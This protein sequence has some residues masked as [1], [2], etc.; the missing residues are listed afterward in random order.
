MRGRGV[1]FSRCHMVVWVIRTFD[2]GAIPVRRMRRVHRHLAIG[3]AVAVVLVPVTLT[4]AVAIQIPVSLW[5]LGISINVG[6]G[7]HPLV[8][9]NPRSK[10]RCAATGRQLCEGRVMGVA[11]RLSLRSGHG[12]HV[13]L[14]RSFPLGKWGAKSLRLHWLGIL[15]V[16]ISLVLSLV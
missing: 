14:P 8:G 1:F 12:T 15:T 5:I 7:P 3:R 13:R 4:F 11:M 2:R 16:P 10:V 9:M 6:T